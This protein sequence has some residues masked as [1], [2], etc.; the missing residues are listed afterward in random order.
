[1]GMQ[2]IDSASEIEPG[3][4]DFSNICCRRSIFE[5]ISKTESID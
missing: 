4:I 3:I 1:M 5:I 2:R